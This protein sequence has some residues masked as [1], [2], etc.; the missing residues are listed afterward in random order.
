MLGGRDAGRKTDEDWLGV[1]RRVKKDMPVGD[2]GT[3]YPRSLQMG[4]RLKVWYASFV[5]RP[6]HAVAYFLI[7]N[8]TT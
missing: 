3:G 2:G 1:I 6:F 7:L 8:E 5:E 4:M